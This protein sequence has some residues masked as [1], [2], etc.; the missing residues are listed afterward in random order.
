LD[1]LKKTEKIKLEY[2]AYPVLFG[3]EKYISNANVNRILNR[4]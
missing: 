2:M 3:I 4:L 1:I